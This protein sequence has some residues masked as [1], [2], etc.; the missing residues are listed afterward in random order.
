MRNMGRHVKLL[1]HFTGIYRFFAAAFLLVTCPRT[2][3]GIDDFVLQAIEA[4]VIT[5]LQST[6]NSLA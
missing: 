1:V 5:P 4:P 3:L 2:K 6:L